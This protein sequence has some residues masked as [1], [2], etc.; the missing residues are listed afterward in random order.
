MYIGFMQ[1]QTPYMAATKPS[2]LC[3]VHGTTSVHRLSTSKHGE[4]NLA[5]PPNLCLSAS[6]GPRPNCPRTIHGESVIGRRS[7][8]IGG[9]EIIWDRGEVLFGLVEQAMRS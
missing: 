8:T 5:T 2:S 3:Q 9:L 4:R 7:R 6:A 1:F